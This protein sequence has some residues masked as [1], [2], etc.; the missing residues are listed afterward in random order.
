MSFRLDQIK[1]AVISGN[2][3]E[4]EALIE[5]AID[6]KKEPEEIINGALISAM[7]VVGKR[8]STGSIYIP[9]MLISAHTMKKGLEKIKP[10]LKGPVAQK[11]ATVL[12]ATVKGD[13]HDIGKNI[14]TMMLE[15]AGFNV[16][17]LG[18]D[19]PAEAI[20]E[21]VRQEKP[22]VI[23]LSALLTTTMAEMK[24]VIESLKSAGIRGQ[25]KVMV[26]GAPLDAAFAEGIGA[27]GYGKDA[28]EAV[29]MVRQFLSQKGGGE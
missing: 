23:G 21:S 27:D 29:K 13:L 1:D 16:I 4:I 26:G 2:Y 19:L 3:G 18:V 22:Q 9:E 7:D 28:T 17:D 6:D 12:I 10:F 14:V 20:V 8:F 11:K 25:V 24:K 15:G 5:K